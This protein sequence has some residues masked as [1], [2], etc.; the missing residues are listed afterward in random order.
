M[1]LGKSQ[2]CVFTE[3]MHLCDILCGIALCPLL[4]EIFW[5]V[6]KAATL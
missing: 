2:I 1:T 4:S 5:T 3:L 6:K